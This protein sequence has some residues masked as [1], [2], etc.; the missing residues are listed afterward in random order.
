MPAPVS[1]LLPA[2]LASRLSEEQLRTLAEAPRARRP[3]LLAEALRLGEPEA[4]LE[5]S[6]ASGLPVATDLRIEP[7]AIPLLPARLIRDFHLAPLA[8]A[9]ADEQQ[10]NLATPWLPEQEMP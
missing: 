4:R 5:L 8:V 3:A 1:N 2:A 6:R 9:G 7:A 10:L